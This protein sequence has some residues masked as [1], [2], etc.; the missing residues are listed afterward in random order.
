MDICTYKNLHTAKPQQTLREKIVEMIRTSH[1]L[2]GFTMNAR[3]HDCVRQKE[4]GVFIKKNLL[5]AFASAA[6]LLYVVGCEKLI[7]LRG[8]PFH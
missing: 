6:Y 3:L 8:T 1:L 5:P 2:Q 4:Q 7:G